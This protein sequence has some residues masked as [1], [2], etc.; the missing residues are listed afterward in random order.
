MRS[1]VELASVLEGVL[2][3][4]TFE[5]KSGKFYNGEAPPV[6]VRNRLKVLAFLLLE[7]FKDFMSIR[8]NVSN[9]PFC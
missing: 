2:D 6:R 1:R 5:F 9:F 3:L 4:R 8:E 7:N